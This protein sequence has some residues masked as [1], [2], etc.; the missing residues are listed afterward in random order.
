[1][2]IFDFDYTLPSRLIAQEPSQIREESRL[3][4]VNRNK[5]T[6]EHR[7]FFSEII[8]V[9][10]AGDLLVLNDTKVI[11]ARLVGKSTT[12]GKV[13]ILIISYRQSQAEV[14]IQAARHPRKGDIY[15]FA[16]YQAHV[17][18]R[19]ILGWCLDFH[20]ED[21]EHIMEQQGS[22]PLPP[23]IKRKGNL[24]GQFLQKDR[25][26]YQTVYAKHPGAIA[27][28]TAGLHFSLPLLQQLKQKGVEISYV[29]LHVGVA[30][31]LPV[32][33]ENVE[34]HIMAKEYYS[35]PSETANA[36]KRVKNNGKRVIAIGTTSCRTLETVGK[37]GELTSKE[38]W[39]DLFIYPPYKF[40]IVDG[41]ITNFHL[42][43]STLL[44]LISA[45][46]GKE[47]VFDVYQDAIRNS[48]RFYSYGDAMAIL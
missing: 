36:I 21:V 11:P 34:E 10:E 19:G 48:Y 2:K 26:R 14:L 38:G 40:Q 45:F 7:R 1:M 23:Y 25:D 4:V 42:P 43:R 27:A 30:T 37:F 18:D 8:E 24:R 13:E 28:P 3:I 22:P 9:L 15:H 44:M 33:C 20:D 6:W 5:K 41:L 31:F 12:G 17:L 29:T 47:L 32:K 35:I 16:S 39:S 46:A